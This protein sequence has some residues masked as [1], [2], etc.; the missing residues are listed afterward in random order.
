MTNVKLVRAKP[1]YFLTIKDPEFPDIAQTW[2]ITTDELK[3]IYEV[4][5]KELSR[6]K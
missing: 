4:V 3:E 1:G 2:A 5:K 6:L